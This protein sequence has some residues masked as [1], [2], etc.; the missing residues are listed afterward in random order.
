MAKGETMTGLRIGV[1]GCGGIGRTHLKAYR[2]NGITPAALAEPNEAALRSAQTEYGGRPYHDYRAMF[3]AEQLDA[4]SVCTPP[5]SHPE[6]AIA[7]LEAGIAVLC[8]KPMATTSDACQQM[9]AAQGAG[10]LLMVG[11]CHRFQPQVERLRE[12]IL[13]GD[14]GT[15]LM[16]RNRF[17]GHLENVERTWFARPEIAGGGV[18]FDTCVHSVDLFRYLI[19]EPT[20]VQ[21][22]TATTATPLGPALD[23][24]DTAIITLRSATGALGVIEASWRTPPG[25]WTLAVYGTAGTAVIDYGTDE[26]RLQ[27]ADSGD[28]QT[29][30]VPP[31]DRFAR[32]IAHFLACVRG[33]ATPRVTAHD[34]LAATRII[35]AAY[36]STRSAIAS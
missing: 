17:A 33:A 2:A 20:A 1:V 22:L 27:Q 11:F 19:G 34:G 29:L 21:A 16:F 32:E 24:E 28:W 36:E 4:I 5:A 12:L 6:I 26:L 25:E 31:G 15:V 9:I 30:D 8:E 3:A 35:A 14:L 10:K 7:A 18:I 13:S 23:V